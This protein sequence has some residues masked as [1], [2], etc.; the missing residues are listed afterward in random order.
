MK[1]G[2]LCE[3]DWSVNVVY[4][5]LGKEF[6]KHQIDTSIIDIRRYRDK[7]EWNNYINHYD[8]F[9]V[10]T[11]DEYLTKYSDWGLPDE[12]LIPVVHAPWEIESMVDTYG[13]NIFNRYPAVFCVSNRIKQLSKDIK[14][15]KELDVVQN[16]IIFD[17]FYCKPSE[18]LVRVGYA[19][20]MQTHH[21]WKRVT[22]PPKI[23]GGVVTPTHVLP[24][25]LMGQFYKKIDASILTSTHTEACGLINLEAAAAGRMIIST[26]VGILEDYPNAPAIRVRMEEDELLD[27]IDNTIRYYKY[28]T[29]EFK[30]RCIETQEFA[31][32]YYS[33]DHAVKSWLT[34]LSK[35]NS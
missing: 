18:K 5:G 4:E 8:Y 3:L 17:R 19:Y 22:I 12:K 32:E 16:G 23:T 6:H 14:I 30:R 9:F 2:F 34:G 28:H 11:G 29:E 33:W 10:P 26:D 7:Y 1:I 27:D 20:P 25:P 35:L 21:E 13:V 15:T 24:Y 31:R